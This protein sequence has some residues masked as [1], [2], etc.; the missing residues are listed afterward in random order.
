M[1]THGYQAMNEEIL[2]FVLIAH[3][4]RDITGCTHCREY[5][6]IKPPIVLY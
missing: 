1:I 4:L 6:N 5:I 3:W 2:L